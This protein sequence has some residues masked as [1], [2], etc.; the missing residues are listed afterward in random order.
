LAGGGVD[1][2]VLDLALDAE[3]AGRR[4]LDKLQPK[5]CPIVVFT[6]QDES[7]L[8]GDRWEEL[9][10]LGADDLVIKGMHAGESLLRKVAAL[11]GTS[12]EDLEP[13]KP[14]G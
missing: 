4:L 3:D 10:R 13:A 8:Y 1:L 14:I 12:L 6:A 11:L 2:L 9:A 7:E 5:P